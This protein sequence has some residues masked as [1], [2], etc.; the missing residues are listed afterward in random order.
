MAKLTTPLGIVTGGAAVAG[1]RGVD[2]LSSALVL[3]ACPVAPFFALSF[4]PV[5]FSGLN[6]VLLLADGPSVGLFA[7]PEPPCVCDAPSCWE[8]F[9]SGGSYVCY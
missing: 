9:S 3:I 1:V 6:G 2:V 5:A 7:S 8:A 4:S